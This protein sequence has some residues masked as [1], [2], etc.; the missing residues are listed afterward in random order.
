MTKSGGLNIFWDAGFLQSFF[1][2]QAA[3]D[4]N[5]KKIAKTE[6]SNKRVALLVLSRL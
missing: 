5:S 1:V 2:P 6:H 4:S 3:D